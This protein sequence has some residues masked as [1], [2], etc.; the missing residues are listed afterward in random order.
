MLYFCIVS[1]IFF[2]FT[3]SMKKPLL[4]IIFLLIISIGVALFIRFPRRDNNDIQIEESQLS[5]NIEVINSWNNQELTWDIITTGYKNPLVYTNKEFDFQLTLPEWWEDYRVFKYD[6][7]KNPWYS[8][9]IA[10]IE[11]ALP[12]NESTRYW[13]QDPNDSN[14]LVWEYTGQYHYITWYANMI[15]VSIW[16]PQ[17]YEKYRCENNNEWWC[18]DSGELLWKNEKYNY[19]LI[20]PQDFPTD[21]YSIWWDRNYFKQIIPTFKVL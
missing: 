12:T 15:W 10:K 9:F 19:Q 18:I 13:I 4:V 14:Y 20:W 8:W 6:M 7:R 2:S 21:I 16:D 5:W 3:D 17:Y 1:S 11:I